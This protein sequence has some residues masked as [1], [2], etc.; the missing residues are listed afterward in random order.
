MKW[1]QNSSYCNPETSEWLYKQSLKNLGTL[2][3]N[4]WRKREQVK[5]F[6]LKIIFAK[7]ILWVFEA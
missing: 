2:E 1:N 6:Y 4:M 3:Y 5:R 7:F